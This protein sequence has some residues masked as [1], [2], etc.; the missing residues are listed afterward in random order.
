[1][2]CVSVVIYSNFKNAKLYAIGLS[3]NKEWENPDYRQTLTIHGSEMTGENELR[4]T[5]LVLNS[6]LQNVT[7]ANAS[8][9]RNSFLK[10]IAKSYEMPTLIE[11]Q[12]LTADE[13]K[14]EVG[15]ITNELEIL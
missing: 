13:P 5:T 10:E 15:K 1:M 6:I 3:T 11:G 14:R 7:L 12:N 9:I 8:E 2:E 4:E